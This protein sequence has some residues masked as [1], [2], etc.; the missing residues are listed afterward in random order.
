MLNID[1]PE[2]VLYILNKL[3]NDGFEAYIVGGCVRDSIMKRCPND[4]DVTTSALP[5]QILH[6]FKD[7]KTIETGKKFGTITVI[8][9]SMPIEI[10]TF[11]AESEYKDSRR[12]EIIEFKK[13][14]IEDLARRDFT[15]NSIGYHPKIGLIDPFEG[16][17]DINLKVI[18]TVGNPYNRFSE[19]A[20]RILRAIRFSTQL[21]FHIENNTYKAIIDLKAQLKNI[22]KERIRDEFF[23]ILLSDKPS[24][25]IRLLVNTGLIDY[26]VPEIVESVDFNQHNPHHDKNVFDH[27]LCAVDNS[28]KII[29][30]RLAALFH[31]ISKPDT[32]TLDEEGIGHFYNHHKEGSELSKN[33]LKRLHSPKKLIETVSVLVKEHMIGH[34]E[35]SDKGLK[36]LINRVGK[37]DI[38]KLLDLMRADTICTKDS[39]D[40]KNIDKLEIRITEILNRKDP[41]GVKDLAIDGKDLINLG[42]SEGP[43]IGRILKELFE[44]VMED[45]KL[46]SHAKLLELSKE[47][48]KRLG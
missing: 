47:I 1:I 25:G 40:V 10:T 11:R 6:V 21:G 20:L 8:K 23:K 42:I 30:N 46:N 18:K 48:H 33:I 9:D 3:N 28:P 12:P 22:S 41:M 2:T 24:I 27:I 34:N 26:I 43:E 17:N 31:D 5:I 7:E 4:W 45:E 39:E 19:D 32:F 16:K 37:E 36:R 29:E 15:I 14:I 38:Y 44:Y 35:F 13:D